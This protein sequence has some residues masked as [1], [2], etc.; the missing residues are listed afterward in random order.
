M[1]WIVG[2][3][4]VLIAAML[5]DMDLLAYAMYVLLAVIFSSRFLE[6]DA[7]KYSIS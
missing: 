6:A 5:F 3:V 4:V 2:A 7:S 1:N